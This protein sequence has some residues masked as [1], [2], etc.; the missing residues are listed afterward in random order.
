VAISFSSGR[1]SGRPQTAGKALRE[2]RKDRDI[3]EVLGLDVAF[4]GKEG[5]GGRKLVVLNKSMAWQARNVE[6]MLF[7]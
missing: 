4:W 2:Y 1:S 3:G 6:R 5:S 7:N